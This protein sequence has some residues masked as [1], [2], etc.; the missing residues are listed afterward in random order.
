MPFA[1][2]YERDIHFV[3]HGHKFGASDALEYERMADEFM[4]GPLGAQ[5]HECIR[6]EGIDRIRFDFGTRY[7]GVACRAPEF[8]RTFYPVRT[9]TIARHGGE[10]AYF[11]YECSRRGGVNL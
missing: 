3:K 4:F 10:A 1:N 9:T 6:P 2:A 5:T 7:E 8:L 11:A